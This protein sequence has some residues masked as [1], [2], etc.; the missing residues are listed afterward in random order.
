MLLPKRSPILI[1][2]V[3]LQAREFGR[4]VAEMAAEDGLGGAAGLEQCIAGGRAPAEDVSRGLPH[5]LLVHVPFAQLPE[6]EKFVGFVLR[7]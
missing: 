7:P 4:L 3:A 5:A 6:E 1:D 2:R